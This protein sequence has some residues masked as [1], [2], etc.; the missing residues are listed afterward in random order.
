MANSF[1][2][3][4][5]FCQTETFWIPLELQKIWWGFADRRRWDMKSTEIKVSDLELFKKSK[6]IENGSVKKKLRLREVGDV[7]KKERFFWLS[8]LDLNCKR[9]SGACSLCGQKHTYQRRAR[10]LPTEKLDTFTSSER[11]D[12]T[13]EHKPYS[14]VEQSACFANR[15]NSHYWFSKYSFRNDQVC[16]HSTLFSSNSQK[17]FW[18]TRY[19][20]T[21]KE[22]TYKFFSDENWFW[23]SAKCWCRLET[24]SFIIRQTPPAIFWWT[25]WFLRQHLA[26]IQN[27]FSS[28]KNL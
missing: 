13:K 4:H 12:A 6:I 8:Y 11:R 22:T 2:I 21:V 28:E 20:E 9:S 19:A 10:K 17:L 15:T 23:M 16:W 24:K 7:W 27:Q 25:I 3:C 14:I 18:N 26:D 5:H 1:S